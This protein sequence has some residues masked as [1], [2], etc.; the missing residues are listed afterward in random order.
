MGAKSPLTIQ[1]TP[2]GLEFSNTNT[3]S[4]KSASYATYTPAKPIMKPSIASTAPSLPVSQS[5]PTTPNPTAPITSSPSTTTHSLPISTPIKSSS[6]SSSSS[7]SRPPTVSTSRSR[8]ASSSRKSPSVS[9]AVICLARA[10]FDFA[11]RSSLELSL[12]E[13]EV[14]KVIEKV[15]ET[16]WKGRKLQQVGAFPISYVT[17]LTERVN[18][19]YEVLADYTATSIKELSI[20]RGEILFITAKSPTGWWNA[21]NLVTKA[22]GWIPSDYVVQVI[23]PQS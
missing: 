5:V 9:P 13:G 19:Y 22:T 10:S 12:S 18:D 17:E 3:S 2:N 11:A 8:S 16:W 1:T 4:P 15:D 14:V 6:T 7:R 21:Q 20:V 23:K